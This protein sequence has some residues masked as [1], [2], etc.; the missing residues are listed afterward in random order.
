MMASIC[1]Y[2]DNSQ[3]LYCE[4]NIPIFKNVLLTLK[5]ESIF[6][7]GEKLFEKSGRKMALNLKTVK[8]RSFNGDTWYCGMEG[9]LVE[10]NDG[11]AFNKKLSMDMNETWIHPLFTVM[12]VGTIKTDGLTKNNCGQ[13]W[14]IAHSG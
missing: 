9:H 13:W 7:D 4:Q 6:P 8:T 3:L 11:L 12:S 2:L 1:L 10:N 5:D 14:I